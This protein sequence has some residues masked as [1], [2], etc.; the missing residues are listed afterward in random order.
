MPFSIDVTNSAAGIAGLPVD[1]VPPVVTIGGSPSG[2][3]PS[4]VVVPPDAVGY[5]AVWWPRG[6][7]CDLFIRPVIE[8]EGV[9]RSGGLVIGGATTRLVGYRYVAGTNDASDPTTSGSYAPGVPIH[10][11][12]DTPLAGTGSYPVRVV[13]ELATTYDDGT[14]QTSAVTGTVAVTVVYSAISQ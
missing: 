9:M 7:P 8:S 10:L 4:G 2:T 3:L 11:Q 1:Y 12:W 14:V 13:L 6:L 5:G